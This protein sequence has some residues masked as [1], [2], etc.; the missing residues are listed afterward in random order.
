MNLK[1]DEFITYLTFRCNYSCKM[2][3]QEGLPHPKELSVEEW[4]KIFADI[5]KNYPDAYVVCSIANAKV[6]KKI[7]KSHKNILI[8]NIEI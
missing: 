4:D 8:M 1:I 5:E 3:T 6:R 2:C 7:R